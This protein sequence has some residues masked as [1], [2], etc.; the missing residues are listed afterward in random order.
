VPT[1][2]KTPLRGMPKPADQTGR[3]RVTVRVRVTSRSARRRTSPAP[4]FLTGQD[5]VPV[6]AAARADA[7]RLLRPLAPGTTVTGILRFTP[8]AEAT[9]RLTAKP[10]RVCRSSSGSW[11]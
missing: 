9:Q 2:A 11:R 10:A 4:A 3:A 6:D 7:G 5:A 1:D 8:S